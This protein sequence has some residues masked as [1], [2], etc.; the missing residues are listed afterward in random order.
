MSVVEQ[1]SPAVS[2]RAAAQPTVLIVD[3]T[4]SNLSLL[5]DI[6]RADY[7]VRV[8]TD[9]PK[10][11]AIARTAATQ[12]DLIL[13]DVMMPGM[14]GYEV[15]RQ[16]KADPSTA[17]IPV[18][19]VSAMSEVEDETRGLDVG[20]VDY[21]MKPINASIVRARIRTHLA[22]SGHSREMTRLVAELEQRSAALL[23]L[24]HTLEARVASEVAEVEKLARLKRFFSPSVV[25]LMLS[26][27]VDDPLK[28]HRREIAA[29]FIDLRGFTAF[30]ESSD[31]EEVMGLLAEY[32]D[33]MGRIVMEHGGTLERFAG[34]GIMIFF[35]DPVRVDN[36][37][38]LAVGMAIAMQ[39]RF[40]SL[41]DDWHKRGYDLAMGIGV[42][43]GYATIG[44]IGF[45]G[46]RDY[47]VIGPVTNLAARL[48]AEAKGGQILI[49]PRVH[50]SVSSLVRCELVGELAL[51]GFHRPV[52]V[53][54][55]TGLAE[56]A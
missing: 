11:L 26:N 51:K 31:P 42:A 54:A 34:D 53:H 27:D 4:P 41:I 12:P 32:H 33:A 45:E 23:E 48:C 5:S 50:A 29:A 37:S 55:V 8:A 16:L 22:V 35:N 14:D 36:P 2:S 39:E 15:C 17:A 10:A 20:G 19:F 47:G 43:Q 13:L 46:R 56:A 9:G 28:S 44:A 49:S 40:A 3:D 7:R 25:E 6:L 1:S 38:A 30:A 18:I 24:N 52:I 21:V